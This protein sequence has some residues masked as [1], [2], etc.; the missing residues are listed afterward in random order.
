MIACPVNQ[1]VN[2]Q[3]SKAYAT[4]VWNEPQATD[5]SREIP[6][7]TCDANSGNQFEIGE[8]EVICQAVDPTGN[9][10]TCT[11]TVKINGKRS[12]V[13]NLQFC[14][15]YGDFCFDQMKLWNFSSY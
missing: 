6:T 10:A 2:T 7:I 1:T 11:F 3:P 9:H 13:R 5:N 14:N 8:T 15:G 12:F 4:V